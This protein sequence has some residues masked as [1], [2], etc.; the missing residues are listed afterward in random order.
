MNEPILITCEGVGV[1]GHEMGAYTICVMCGA[2]FDLIPNGRV[3]HHERDD[4]LARI[5]RGDFG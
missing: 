3:P 4:I 2:A 5:N 1:P